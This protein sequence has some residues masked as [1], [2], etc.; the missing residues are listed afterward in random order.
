MT[1]AL[2]Q[3]FPLEKQYENEE[4]III[5]VVVVVVIIMY[6]YTLLIHLII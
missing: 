4:I 1:R 3:A 5:T 2:I 6:L